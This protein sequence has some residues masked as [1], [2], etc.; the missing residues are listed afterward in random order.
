MNKHTPGPWTAIA[1]YEDEFDVVD[2]RG[3]RIVE[4][5]STPILIEWEKALQIDHWADSDDSH[6][7]LSTEEQ[8]ANA[9]LIAAAPEL[10]EALI[11]FM[12][13]FG[14]KSINNKNVWKARAAM[15]P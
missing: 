3:F 9:R 14:D 8:N 2:P 13:E 12:K 11:G 4:A 7:E 10:L 1:A 6:I 5:V 15:M